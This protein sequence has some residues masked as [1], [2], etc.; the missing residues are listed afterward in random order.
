MI[1]SRRKAM[2]ALKYGMNGLFVIITLCIITQTVF[3]GKWSGVPTVNGVYTATPPVLNA[4]PSLS[5]TN[6]GVT[7]VNA[8]YQSGNIEAGAIA[9]TAGNYLPWYEANRDIEMGSDYT[10]YTLFDDNFLYIGVLVTD[11]SV[12]S[13][14]PGL[15]MD[16]SDEVEFFIEKNNTASHYYTRTLAPPDNAVYGSDW[17]RFPGIFMAGITAGVTAGS[18]DWH[19]YAALGS[20]NPWHTG[21]GINALMG[22]DNEGIQTGW[23]HAKGTWANG[24]WVNIRV[25]LLTL[26]QTEQQFGFNVVVKDR[27][28]AGSDDDL[29]RTWFASPLDP[30]LGMRDFRMGGEFRLGVLNYTANWGMIALPEVTFVRQP[31]P[32]NDCYGTIG[33]YFQVTAKFGNGAVPVSLQWQKDGENVS[34][35]TANSAIFYPGYSATGK[36]NYNLEGVYRCKITVPGLILPAYTDNVL[37]FVYRKDSI[38]NQPAP[39]SVRKGETAVF[40]VRGHFH[41]TIAPYLNPKVQWFKGNK[42]LTESLRVTGVHSSV[43]SIQNV[44]V[45]DTGNYFVRVY[46][47]CDSLT[48]VNVGL[49]I[50]PPGGVN[51]TGQPVT[52]TICEGTIATFSLT[53]QMTG[54]GTS[55]KYSWF[56]SGSAISNDARISGATTSNLT[57]NNVNSTDAGNYS[58]EVTVLPD[59]IKKVSSTAALNVNSMPTITIQPLTS[60]DDVSGK[61]ITLNIAATGFAPITYQW[62][63]NSVPI[64]SATS[65]TLTIASATVSNSGTY[66]C[67]VTNPCGS[68]MS[69]P[70]IVTI[71]LLNY[72]PSSVRDEMAGL[73]SFNVSPNPVLDEAS[74]IFSLPASMNLKISLADAF[75]REVALIAKQQFNYGLNNLTISSTELSLVSGMYFL[76]VT[77]DMGKFTKSVVFLR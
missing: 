44:D 48:S 67:Q 34:G 68:I 58:C 25:D 6:A 71:S 23:S 24:Y 46:G 38:I 32:F 15:R 66:T 52:Q 3:A 56:R 53:A 77:S 26:G 10:I 4:D 17:E 72:E 55:L 47:H 8:S 11:A 35:P 40:Q 76:T 36:L 21:S 51:I 12:M 57:I 61:T 16:R 7:V 2:S 9:R 69:E 37:L 62:M 70:S 22:D 59:N 73:T 30:E 1:Y 27:D 39:Q 50:L 20:K 49:T 19:T 43:L 75:G 5:W 63:F 33:R 28:A 64:P 54:S 14:E 31:K 60:I 65:A 45:T 74:I 42:P 13:D 41:D 29:N 18:P